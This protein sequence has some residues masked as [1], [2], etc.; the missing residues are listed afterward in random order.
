MLE[1]VI[2]ASQRNNIS[3]EDRLARLLSKK[4]KW[5]LMV[6]LQIVFCEFH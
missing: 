1:A 5:P 3:Y 6:Q 4:T 2:Q